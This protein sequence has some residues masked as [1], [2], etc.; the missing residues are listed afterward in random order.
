MIAPLLKYLFI[1]LNSESTEKDTNISGSLNAQL[2]GKTMPTNL[3][4]LGECSG[5]DINIV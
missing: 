3:A 1:Q 5:T 4:I 2:D